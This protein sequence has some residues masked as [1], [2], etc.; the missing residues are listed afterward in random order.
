M[1]VC[2]C[3]GGG[4]GRVDGWWGIHYFALKYKNVMFLIVGMVVMDRFFSR[5]NRRSRF[6]ITAS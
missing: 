6:C 3:G 2:V 1:C 4:G 5:K